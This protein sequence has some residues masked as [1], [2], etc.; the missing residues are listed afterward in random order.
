[1]LKML[2][3]FTSEIDEPEAAVDELLEQLNIENNLLKNSVGIVSCYYEFLETGVVEALCAQ[4]PFDVVGC[5]V[6]GNAVNAAAGMEQLSIAVLTSDELNFSTAFSDEISPNDVDGPI[7]G[8]Y[9]DACGKLSGQPSCILAFAPITT[10]ISGEHMLK[11]LDRVSGGTPIFGT[12][13]NDTS[14]TYENAKT[15]RNGEMHAYKI[16]LILIGGDF[17]PKFF[18]TALSERNIQQ[19]SAVVTESEGY[20][21]KRVNDMHLLDYLTSI[22]V[23]THGLAAVTTLP[24]L[25]DYKDG[26]KPTACS[27]YSITEE[28]ALCGV[29]IP[30]GASLTFASVDYNSVL[31]TAETAATTALA[32]AEERGASGMIAIPCL[33][34]CLV[35]TPTSEA[36][37]EKTREII[38]DRMPFIFIYSGGEICPVYNTQGDMINRFH[39]LTYTVAVF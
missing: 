17:N 9:Q 6:I 24:F 19:Q 16:A 30:E 12:L 32:Y 2:T 18:V 14:P 34:R 39:N 31:E 10:D 36:E 4:L 21:L 1:M 37:M 23:D 28:G 33:S 26:T 38:G 13:S 25:V 29:A 27:M 22:G 8:A 15:F 35:I 20:R 3:A 11:V 5:T 7:D